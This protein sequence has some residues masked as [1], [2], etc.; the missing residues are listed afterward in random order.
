MGN[1]S[2]EFTERELNLIKSAIKKDI[3]DYDVK[4]SQHKK[5]NDRLYRHYHII[6]QELKTL[7]KKLE[8]N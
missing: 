3:F 2:F 7:L 8:N 6:K 1:K 4:E 5:Y